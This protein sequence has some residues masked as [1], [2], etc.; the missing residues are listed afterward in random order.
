MTIPYEAVIPS[1]PAEPKGLPDILAE[2]ESG[3]LPAYAFDH[4]GHVFAAWSAMHR[5]GVEQGAA[6]FRQALRRYCGHLNATDKYH[7]TITEAL[8]RLVA[9]QLPDDMPPDTHW[10]VRWRRFEQ[11]AGHLLAS[12][13][14]ALAPH[15]SI[16][17]IETDAARRQ[18][19]APDIASL[20]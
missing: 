14:A 19:L 5:H 8:I 15:Y 11:R 6:R 7:V 16:A 10:Q 2:L 13:K 12:S 9:V 18:F 1:R 3:E 4:R 17:L 20:P